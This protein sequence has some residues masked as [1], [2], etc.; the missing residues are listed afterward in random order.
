MVKRGRPKV[1]RKVQKAPQI[2]QFSP[3]GRPGRPEEVALALD[4]LEAIRLADYQNFEQIQGAAAMGISRASFGRILR[5][6]RQKVADALSNG[7]ILR[8]VSDPAIVVAGL[9]TNILV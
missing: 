2:L 1:K 6:G 4:E 5:T 7:K 9:P 8:I 3:R